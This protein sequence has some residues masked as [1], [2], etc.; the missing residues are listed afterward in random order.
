MDIAA[1]AT[2]TW[3]VLEQPWHPGDKLMLRISL[4]NP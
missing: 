3:P 4:A 1:D 2:L